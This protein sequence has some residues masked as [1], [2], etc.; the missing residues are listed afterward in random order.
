MT[1]RTPLPTLLLA[2]AVAGAALAAALVGFGLLA[3]GGLLVF[4]LVG[5]CIVLELVGLTP[6]DLQ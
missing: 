3:L 6:A 5:A 1:R 4:V 2:D